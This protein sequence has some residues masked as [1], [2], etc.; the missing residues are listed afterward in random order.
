MPGGESLAFTNASSGSPSTITRRLRISLNTRPQVLP[1]CLD[2][3]RPYRGLAAGEAEE[4]SKAGAG[5]AEIDILSLQVGGERGGEDLRELAGEGDGAVVFG[6][7]DQFRVRA[8]GGDDFA[9]DGVVAV[10][11][12]GRAGEEIGA[13]RG[14]A[15]LLRAGQGVAGDEAVIPDGA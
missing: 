3:R 14:E 7:F 2:D 5:E 12:P 8:A 13:G 4:G 11:E 9:D 15:V 6:G 1:I 10:D